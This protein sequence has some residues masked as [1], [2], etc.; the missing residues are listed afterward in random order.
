MAIREV[1]YE[2]D[3]VLR[4][5]CKPVKAIDQ[6]LIDLM[7][8][9]EDTMRENE[10]VG[11]AAPQIGILRRCVVI[12]PHD[13][14]DTFYMVNPEIVDSEGEQDCVEGCL[15]V[16]NKRG[17]VKRPYRVVCRYFDL[18]GNEIELD[19]EGFLANII[20]HELDHLDGTL[21]I[22]KAKMLSDKEYAEYLSQLDDEYEEEA[23][24]QPQE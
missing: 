15:S 8:D 7:M 3:S 5:V 16:P 9:M 14:S 11:L 18:E 13:G 22:D 1:R 4:K 23:N 10:G 6:K 24:E 19:A 2:G 21:Y 20:C 12:D 17:L